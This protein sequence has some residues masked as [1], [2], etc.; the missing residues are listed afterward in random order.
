METVE[1]ELDAGQE[2]IVL[3]AMHRVTEICNKKN[4][5][6]TITRKRVLE[7][8]L[9][10]QQPIGAY[11]LLD[12]LV[13]DG[14]NAAPTTVYRALDFL[15]QEGFIHR[16]SSLNAFIGCPF[17]GHT[18]FS[19]F[20]ICNQCSKVEELQNFEISQAIKD[21]CQNKNF[22]IKN[23]IIEIQGCCKACQN[24]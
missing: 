24:H 21:A 15:L 19:Q 1:V 22:K 8:I 13:E 14:R 9:Q 16:L 20:F 5:R 18:T 2:N 12:H 17:P 7:L 6:L 23:E 10:A 11:S 3:T 4:L